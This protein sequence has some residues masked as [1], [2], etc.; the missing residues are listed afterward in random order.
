MSGKLKDEAEKSKWRLPECTLGR[1]RVK[2]VFPWCESAALRCLKACMNLRLPCSDV[3][4][5]RWLKTTSI[6]NL[7]RRQETQHSVAGSSAQ[8]LKRRHW[9]GYIPIRS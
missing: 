6:Y 7:T 1:E 4:Q 5:I 8:G 2:S 9:Q 3:P